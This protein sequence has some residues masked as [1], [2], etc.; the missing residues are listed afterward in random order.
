MKE[1][2]KF[3]K[4]HVNES[5][6][7]MVLNENAFKKIVEVVDRF[8]RKYKVGYMIPTSNRGKA[9]LYAPN[10]QLGRFIYETKWFNMV[11]IWLYTLGLYV[12]LRADLLRKVINISETRRLRRLS[13]RQAT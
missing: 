7:D 4:E 1:Y 8:I 12:M 11:V 2:S 13:R 3:E 5:L 10:K 6:N 9:H